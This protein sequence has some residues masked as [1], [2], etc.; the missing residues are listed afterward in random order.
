M[1]GIYTEK[2]KCQVMEDK[3]TI[4]TKRSLKA[5]MIKMLEKESF[6]SI[7][8]TEL[9]REA[10]VSRITFYS[11]YS[12]KY[13]LLDDIFNDLLIIGTED[14]QRRQRENNQR[15]SLVAGYVNVLDSIL[16]LYYDRFDFFRHTNP[17]KNPYLASRYYSIVLETVEKH[18]AHVKERLRL[19][20]SPKKIAG[21]MCFGLFGFI[22]ESREEK[23][24]IDQIEQEARMLL[25]D[26]LRSGVLTENEGNPARKN[27]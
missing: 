13:A 7:S 16:K 19:K 2:E 22:N 9:C 8:I 24:P 17:E 10:D 27:G 3:R 15:N 5:A 18:T 11:H 23:T 6:E 4:K 1:S 25:T 20:Y 26:M 14:Y 21:F 12:D